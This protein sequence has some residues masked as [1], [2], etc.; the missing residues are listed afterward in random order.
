MLLEISPCD[1]ETL[2]ILCVYLYTGAWLWFLFK[3]LSGH[4]VTVY[5]NGKD[6]HW[7]PFGDK[8]SFIFPEHLNVISA[9]TNFFL[10]QNY[11][12]HQIDS[13]FYSAFFIST[14]PDLKLTRF[15]L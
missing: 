3:S 10:N 9:S 8:L 12:K 15:P 6:I 14:L 7:H 11:L 5:V 1:W 2:C 4:G 13:L